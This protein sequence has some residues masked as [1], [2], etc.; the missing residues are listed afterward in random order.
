MCVCDWYCS[1]YKNFGEEEVHAEIGVR[2][3]ATY[4]ELT[5]GGVSIF[6]STFYRMIIFLH[7]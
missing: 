1:I 7:Y 4:R 2:F 3:L 6:I 5:I